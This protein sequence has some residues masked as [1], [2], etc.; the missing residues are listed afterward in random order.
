[1]IEPYI[2]PLYQNLLGDPIARLIGKFLSPN[3]V[4]L[5][6]IL[7]GIAIVPTLYC[8][9]TKLA[10]CLL[11][12]S[13][14]L[15]TIDGTVA[16][17]FQ[18]DSP[19][20]SA[21]DVVGDRIVELSI[22]LGLFLI[23]PETRALACFIMLGSVLICV[24]SFLVVGIFSKNDSIK[25]FHYSPGLMERLEAFGFFAAMILLPNYFHILS[26]LFSFLVFL[27]A[28]LRM[29]EFKRAIST[30]SSFEGGAK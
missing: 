20:G 25:S 18:K 28:G 9:F 13:G 22:L 3:K 15:D 21:L 10:F 6:S 2:R 7:I 26:L 1:M 19:Y 4:T 16:R 23:S 5:L 24:T 8:G 27:T 17:L 12:L 11:I 14:F 30:L 29:V